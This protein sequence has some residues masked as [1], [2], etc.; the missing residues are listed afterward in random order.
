MDHL[1]DCASGIHLGT[2]CY[3]LQIYRDLRFPEASIVL[4]FAF[5]AISSLVLAIPAQSAV[6]VVGSGNIKVS[7]D[8]NGSYSVTVPDLKWTFSGSVGIP[9]NN[10]RICLLYTSP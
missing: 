2:M 1:G 9:L 7:V 3:R 4:R 5:F 6:T 8:P 10:L